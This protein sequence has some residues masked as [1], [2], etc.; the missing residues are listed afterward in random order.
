MCYIL[1]TL[2]VCNHWVPQP[3]PGHGPSKERLLRICEESEAMRLGNP[4]PT[5]EHRVSSRSQ[6]MCDSCLWKKVSK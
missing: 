5:T 4:C 3:Q 1:Y 2:H 6:G